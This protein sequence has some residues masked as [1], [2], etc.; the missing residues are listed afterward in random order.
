MLRSQPVGLPVTVKLELAPDRAVR[1]VVSVQLTRVELVRGNRSERGHA[2]AELELRLTSATRGA[3][4]G[5]DLVIGRGTFDFGGMPEALAGWEDVVSL[6]FPGARARY[7]LGR[8]AERLAAAIRSRPVRM[9]ESLAVGFDSERSSAGLGRLAE[10]GRWRGW[11]EGTVDRVGPVYVVVRLRGGLRLELAEELG[12]AA[13][14]TGLRA[15]LR[16]VFLR[17]ALRP[18]GALSELRARLK[19]EI[20]CDRRTGLPARVVLDV[21]FALAGLRDGESSVLS[22]SVLVRTPGWIRFEDG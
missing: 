1:G 16:G 8:L 10:L 20:R 5:H 21:D 22:G 3:A 11:I 4:G 6:A 7:P 9:G 19:G 13:E 17:S 18:L 2:G 12:T 14:A 15:G